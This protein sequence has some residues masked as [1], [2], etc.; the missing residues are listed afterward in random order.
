MT[1]LTEKVAIVTGGA[2]GL[3]AAI[4][5]QYAAAGATVVIADIRSQEGE[6][7]VTE[8]RVG[9]G[10]ADFVALDVTDDRAVHDAIADIE[11]R[12]GR[13]DVMTANAGVLGR[14]HNKSVVDMTDDERDM[15]MA[16]N[17]GGV[18]S[19]FRHA[20]PAILRAGGGTMTATASTSSV[21]GIA[22]A[23]AYAAS[24]A[25][26]M[27]LVQSLAVDLYP[28]IRVNAV[29]PGAMATTLG[30]HTAEEKGLD[31]S[32]VVAQAHGV[33]LADPSESAKSHLYLA[34]DLSA[35]VTGQLILVDRGA[36]VRHP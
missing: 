24:K 30:Q 5:R 19:C 18:W 34:S 13:L 3:G 23:P 7:L 2:S 26:V 4:V 27:G 25:A 32:Q 14:G 1:L 6:A 9:G 35:G 16:V 12:H 20:V 21:R 33:D 17:F 36:T 28:D 10:Q 15:I 22:K 29:G 11:E 8:V 31:V